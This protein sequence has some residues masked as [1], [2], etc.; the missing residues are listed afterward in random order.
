MLRRALLILFLIPSFT[1]NSSECASLI[2]N[3]ENIGELKIILHCLDNKAP[4]TNAA[5]PK[6]FQ[7]RAIAAK[8]IAAGYQYEVEHCSRKN[9]EVK[10]NLIIT[11]K[12]KTI[13]SPDYRE[14]GI[15]TANTNF[16]DEYGQEYSATKGQMG[17]V[18]V[19]SKGPS[20]RKN[21]KDG[22]IEKYMP[23]GIPMRLTL[24][25]TDVDLATTTAMAI[26]IKF[27]YRDGKNLA[28]TY[29]TLENIA[30]N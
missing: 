25:F 13:Y 14:F 22:Y 18:V 12:N 5:N 2:D 15:Y 11:N 16:F 23:L 26:N 10:C 9:K 1:A 30:I 24:T 20:N 8:L 19:E 28:S 21:F 6:P 4:S 7:K 3:M 17:K 29:V 27:S